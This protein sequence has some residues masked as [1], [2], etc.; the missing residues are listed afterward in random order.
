[1]ISPSA[2]REVPPTTNPDLR[3]RQL[4]TSRENIPLVLFLG[5]KPE[6]DHTVCVLLLSAQRPLCVWEAGPRCRP[7]KLERHTVNERTD[8]RRLELL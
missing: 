5:A 6:Q 7:V 8:V 2:S 1:M 3:K 4:L